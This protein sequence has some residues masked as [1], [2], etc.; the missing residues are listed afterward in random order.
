MYMSLRLQT[1]QD[2]LC[3]TCRMCFIDRACS[4]LAVCLTLG[5]FCG[6][7][8][9]VTGSSMLLQE[10]V[11]GSRAAMQALVPGRV[12]LV[13]NSSSGL[14]ELGAICGAPATASKGIQLGP[15][16]NSGACLSP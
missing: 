3:C 4:Y 9:I 6:A 12:V 14:P 2:V 15:A 16:A 7:G 5:M 13:T 1:V 10:S 8:G 11:M